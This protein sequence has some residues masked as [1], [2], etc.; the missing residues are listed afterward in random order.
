MTAP[1]RSAPGRLPSGLPGYRPARPRPCR[2]RVLACRPAPPAR[3]A[4]VLV[5]PERAPGRRPAPS[6]EWG[7]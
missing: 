5:H 4:R 3:P 1:T 6:G 7:V 2:G